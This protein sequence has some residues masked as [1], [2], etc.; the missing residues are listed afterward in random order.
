MALEIPDNEAQMAN[1]VEPLPLVVDEL[2][3]TEKYTSRD[4]FLCLLDTIGC[5]VKER[6]RLLHDGFNSIRDII[7]LYNDNIDDFK[8]HL[9]NS[10]KTWINAPLV[11]MRAFFTPIVVNRLVGVVYYYKCAVKLFHTI[12]DSQEV[13]ALAA[14]SY[15]S[16]YETSSIEDDDEQDGITLPQLNEAKDW[17]SFKDNFNM[18]LSV[19]KGSRGI[20]IDYIIDDTPR[21]YLRTTARLGT[22]NALDID[23]DNILKTSTVHFGPAFK[24]D[25]TL[26]WNKLKAALID[27]PGYNHISSYNNSKNGRGAWQTLCTYYQGEHYQK[28]LREIAFTKLQNTFYRGETARFNFEKYVNIHKHCHK[29]LRDARFNDGEGLDNET[30]IQY[31]RNGIKAEAGIEIALSTSRGNDRYDD[32]DTLIS[33]LSAEVNHHKMRRAQ[34]KAGNPRQVS[35]AQ[36]EAQKNKLK[37]QQNRNGNGNQNNRKILSQV[38]DGKRIEGRRYSREEFGRLT[39]KQRGVCIK[40]QRESRANPNPSDNNPGVAS[41]TR[42]EMQDDLITLGEAMVAG[43]SRATQ[44]N[45]TPD[46]QNQP[47]DDDTTIASNNTRTRAES[48]SVGDMFRDRRTRRR[49]N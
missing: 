20:P 44:D 15:G 12:P 14:T 33:F 45:N 5:G 6:F 49:Q 7:D 27:K 34:L 16:L 26:V 42:Q 41:I 2:T 8:K 35:A 37:N 11:R 24:N 19:T 47:N 22:I 46:N 13:N 29:M 39:S 17:T 36:R 9:L 28:N 10:N 43:V 38:V 32:F 48:G 1:I 21:A 4:A 31:F 25:N 40:L 23:N 18:L 3:I 30:R